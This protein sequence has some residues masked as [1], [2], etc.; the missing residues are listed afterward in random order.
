M[1]T[2]KYKF[3]SQ[4]DVPLSNTENLD[5][6]RKKRWASCLKKNLIKILKNDKDVEEIVDYISSRIWLNQYYRN[7]EIQKVKKKKDKICNWFC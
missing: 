5:K 6:V 1:I 7:I 4:G 3:L 2:S